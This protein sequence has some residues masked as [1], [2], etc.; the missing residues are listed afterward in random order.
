MPLR[1][2]AA[3]L[4]VALYAIA[5]APAQPA[6]A[7]EVPAETANYATILRTINP[8]L[9]IH[10]S[11]S[12]ARSLLANSQRTQLDPNLLMALVTVESSWRQTAVSN[13][14]AR[15]LGQLMPAT[16][17]RL[18]VNPRDPSQNLRGASTYLRT[19]IDRFAS[20]GVNAM[21]D[22]I[23][24]YNAGPLA[25]E[26]ARGIPP[27]H[28][29]QRYVKKV[30][31]QWRKLTARV[32]KT[33][34]ADMR[35]ASNAPDERVWLSNTGASAL[36]ATTPAT[37]PATTPSVPVNPASVNPAPANLAPANPSGPESP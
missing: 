2:A 15:G 12:Y 27:I 10:Q 25:V 18:G 9:Q 3:A 14:G 23:G 37:L 22:A 24:A 16:A 7:A 36:P 13:H 5:A 35:V 17:A 19:L 1:L 21:R 33:F 8:H 4:A 6:G 28:E 30:L 34:A 11:L 20:R 29:T 26:K 31:A 32:A